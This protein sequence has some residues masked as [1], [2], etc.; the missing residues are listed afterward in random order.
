M[1]YLPSS[2]ERISQSSLP[3]CMEEYTTIPANNMIPDRT[4]THKN[5]HNMFPK[6]IYMIVKLVTS[7]SSV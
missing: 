5:L 4:S 1:Q 3:A 6:S 2:E 7:L